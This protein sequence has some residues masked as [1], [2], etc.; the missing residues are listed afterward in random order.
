MSISTRRFAVAPSLVTLASCAT[1]QPPREPVPLQPGVYDVFGQVG[2][3]SVSGRLSVSDQGVVLN[4]SEGSCAGG[5][6][7]PQS[8]GI[9]VGCGGLAVQLTVLDGR[10]ARSARA[11]VTRTEA[12]TKQVCA[13]YVVDRD[14]RK[15]CP[16]YTTEVVEQPVTRKGVVQVVRSS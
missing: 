1:L 16:R 9:V 4:T 15:I 13:E 8:A 3:V 5:Y 14:N 6:V 11:S 10:I 2:G 7:G 12:T